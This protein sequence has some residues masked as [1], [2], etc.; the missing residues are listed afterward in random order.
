MNPREA[1]SS[2]VTHHRV[3]AQSGIAIFVRR[4]SS[5]RIIDP[6][7][8]QVADVFAFLVE[9]S[10][11]WMSTSH[12]RAVCR[13]LFPDVGESFVTNQ[14]R[15]IFTFMN[16]DS[17][18]QHDMLYPACEP[19]M[20]RRLGVEGHHPSCRE[21]YR[22]AVRSAWNTSFPSPDPVNLFQNSPVSPDGD[23]V[24]DVAM[25]SPGDAVTLRAEQDLML[26]VTACSQ[27]VVQI[28]G[29]QCTPIDIE[30]SGQ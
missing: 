8:S 7:G 2:P 10:S 18:G 28:N 13:K 12:T 23:L 6:E 26:I 27:D 1:G 22:N 20:Y 11:K 3:A 9:D 5:V 21:N 17:P 24:P 30:V 16:D 15:P 25:S 4:L 19:A 29:D 14:Y